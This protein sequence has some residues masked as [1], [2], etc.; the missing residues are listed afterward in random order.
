MNI[1]IRGILPRRVDSPPYHAV[2]KSAGNIIPLGHA[3]SET[4]LFFFSGR[5]IAARFEYSR[6]GEVHC[7]RQERT[8]I[9]NAVAVFP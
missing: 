8:W 6:G 4:S 7:L 2:S 1:Q 3:Q 5:A 9:A